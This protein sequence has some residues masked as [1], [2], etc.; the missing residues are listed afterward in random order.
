MNWEDLIAIARALAGGAVSPQ[1]GRPRRAELNRAVSTIYYAA[2]HTLANNNADTLIGSGS[3]ARS[4]PAWELAYRTIDHR[5]ARARCQ[6]PGM[7]RFPAQIREMAA[8]FASLQAPSRLRA[9]SVKPQIPSPPVGDG[10]RG[11]HQSL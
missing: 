8:L 11:G 6:H 9:P 1:T 7:S 5:S 4:D 2:F 3:Q 10:D